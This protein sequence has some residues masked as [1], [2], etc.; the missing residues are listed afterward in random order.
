M[1]VDEAALDAFLAQ[2]DPAD[3]PAAVETPAAPAT[4]ETPAAPADDVDAPLPEG[5]KFERA[6]VEKLRREA[7][8]YRERAK[9]AE[10]YTSAFD[11]Y[12]DDAVGEWLRLAQQLKADPK[13]TAAE[14]SQLVEQINAA[15]AE[16]VEGTPTPEEVQTPEGYL[17][18]EDVERMFQER[19]QKADLDRR[20][21]QIENDARNLGYEVGSDSY[22]ELLW[23]ASRLPSGSIQEAHAKIE[24]RNQAIYDKMIADVGGRPAPKV[25]VGSTPAGTDRAIKTFAEAN[26][27]LDQW[28]ASQQ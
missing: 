1:P 8:G 13:S 3:A 16:D 23:N 4:P 21:V 14:L 22:E 24:A 6:Y 11:G 5:D 10:R 27:A 15:Y 12:E 9:A 7:A 17:R 2:P 20:V 18:K 28:L 25:P 19:E 26:E